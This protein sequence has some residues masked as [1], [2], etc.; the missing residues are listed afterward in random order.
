M[1]TNPA[2]PERFT[3][4]TRS[5]VLGAAVIVCVAVTGLTSSSSAADTNGFQIVQPTPGGIDPRPHIRSVQETQNN[6]LL[7]WFGFKGPYQIQQKAAIDGPTWTDVGAPVNGM[8]TTVPKPSGT[9]F[10]HVRGASPLFVGSETCAECHTTTQTTWLKT[11]HADAF[12]TLKAIGQ[13]DN[14]QCL[15]CHTVGYGVPVTGFISEATTPQ[16]KDVQCENCHGPAGEHV[17]WAQAGGGDPRIVPVITRSA[18]LC[19]GCHND[20]H[21]PTYDEWSSSPHSEVVEALV[22]DFSSTNRATAIGRM[23]T[24]GAC[25]SGAV[26]LEMIEAYTKNTGNARTNVA[27]PSGFDAT[28]T[29][30]TCVVCHD[31]HDTHKYTNVLT[32]VVYTNQLRYPLTST[33]FFSYNTGTNFA[34]QY[35]TTVNVCGQCHNARGATVGSTSRAPHHSVQY[36]I[37]LG[38]IGITTN[39]VPPQGAHRNNSRQCA[40]CH[41]HRHD[42]DNPTEENP[43][44]TGHTFRPTI[45]ACAACHTATTGPLSPTNLLFTVQAEI[46]GMIDTTKNLLDLWA[47]TKNTNS[48]ASKYEALGWEYTTPGQLSNPTG[49][50]TIKGPTSSEQ[51]QIPQNIKDARF[52]LYLIEHDASK[53]I[54]NAPYA[55]Y[56]LGVAQDKVNIE[57][58]RP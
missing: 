53:G 8:T 45:P 16:L 26:R 24:C 54:H 22:G 14:A 41:T 11:A 35:N 17:A 18:M 7:E 38:N 5:Y 33:N 28:N 49:S 27:W 52:N 1:K 32:G 12:N 55:R 23:N 21:H 10:Y 44:F 20:F 48:W 51:A 6:L 15:V 40:G 29:A 2:S 47:T 9:A 19:G 30:T 58:N 36:N 56:L 31:T 3:F 43:A 4:R 57:L 42:E 39:A 13:Q 25:H 37:L 50:S 34:S 46:S